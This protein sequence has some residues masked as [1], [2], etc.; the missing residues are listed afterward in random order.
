MA[1]SYPSMYRRAWPMLCDAL[2]CAAKL[3][4]LF[5]LQLTQIQRRP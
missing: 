5:E 2:K 1:S 3:Q 4:L